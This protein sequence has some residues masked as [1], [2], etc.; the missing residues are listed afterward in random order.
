MLTA[1]GFGCIKFG[2]DEYKLSPTFTNIS[3]LGTPQ[4]IIE[5]F[6]DFIGA[7][8]AMS[9][10]L[11]GVQVLNACCEPMLPESLIGR[12]KPSVR[13]NGLVYVQPSHGKP[14]FEDVITLAHHCL[15]HGIC[16]A[17]EQDEDDE[18]TGEPIKEFDAYHYMELA[19]THLGLSLDDA[20]NMTM[21]E[22]VRM[23]QIKFPPKRNENRVSKKEEKEMLAWIEE[24][25]KKG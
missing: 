15:K 11:L 14:M 8:S 17:V 9:Q 5:L 7:T 12:V 19:R 20:S 3:K 2:G 22:F 1:Y 13:G 4:E 16:G 24:Q 6:R 23:M 21:T 10:Y 25:N 18:P